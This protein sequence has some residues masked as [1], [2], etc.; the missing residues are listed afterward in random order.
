[1]EEFVISIRCRPEDL[2]KAVFDVHVAIEGV[3]Q[4]VTVPR[5]LERD[6]GDWS[7]ILEVFTPHE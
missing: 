4:W 2:V 3:M 1:M 5:Q 7:W 6:A